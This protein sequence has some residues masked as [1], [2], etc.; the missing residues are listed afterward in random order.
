MGGPLVP[1]LKATQHRGARGPGAL[2]SG[3]RSPLHGHLCGQLLW[4][5]PRA[6]GLRGH[7]AGATTGLHVQAPAAS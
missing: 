4:I 5:P 1:G 6:D 7:A 3:I 2:Q